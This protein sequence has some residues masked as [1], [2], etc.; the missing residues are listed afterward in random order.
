MCRVLG[1]PR[2]TQRRQR[3]VP[4]DEPRLIKDMVALAPQYGRYGYSRRDG[5][6]CERF[7]TENDTLI[8]KP[9]VQTLT[10]RYLRSDEAHK[11]RKSRSVT[12]S[13]VKPKA[14]ELYDWL[15]TLK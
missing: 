11:S 5:K 10:V 13:T 3:H 14:E 12:F 8:L 7:L 9:G 6:A 1:Q 15:A 2:A 4:D